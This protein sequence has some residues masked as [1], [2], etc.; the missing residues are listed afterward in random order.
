MPDGSSTPS[1]TVLLGCLLEQAREHALVLLDVE[2]RIVGWLAGAQR[3]LGY[4]AEEAL[5]QKVSLFFTPEDRALGL[6]EHELTTAREHGKAEDD[7]WQVR[8][9]GMRIWVSGVVDAL[10]DENG[11][12]IGYGK[13]MR[14]RTDVKA[15]LDAWENQSRGHKDVSV[16][17]ISHELGTT[18]ASLRISL[19]NASELAAQGE[20]VNEHLA[21]MRRQVQVTEHLLKD[22]MS[23]TRIEE[24][25]LS[26]DRRR[27]ILN[28]VLEQALDSCRP[29]IDRR[30]QRLQYLPPPA[31]LVVE[32]D[33]TRLHEVFVNLLTNASKYTPE[34]GE[35]SVKMTTEGDVALVR[36]E[37]NGVGIDA[38]VLP[39]IF[40]L[41]TQEETSREKS[42]GGLGIGLWLVN[43]LVVM[44]GGTVAVR[45]EGK[46]R[47][48]EFSVRLPLLQGVPIAD[49]APA[50][51]TDE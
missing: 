46:G 5:G 23:V 35:I 26:L 17:V 33:P 22:L 14:D 9:D 36:I 25:K 51:S 10:R 30:R 42:Q 40:E 43:N 38:Q 2:G 15:Q 39:R 20:D 19:E 11:A 37:D 44:H 48:A 21:A 16:G 31:F 6:D 47:G 45:S 13:I 41:F 24:G 7:R 49:D 29:L 1:I 12:L 28:D 3:V 32:G 27:L 4:R 50:G 18:F 34:E 8:Q